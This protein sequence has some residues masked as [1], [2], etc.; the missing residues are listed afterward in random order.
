MPVLTISK[1]FDKEGEADLS[2]LL[3]SKKWIGTVGQDFGSLCLNLSLT[4]ALSEIS[5]AFSYR[6]IPTKLVDF[7]EV[8]KSAEIVTKWIVDYFDPLDSSTSKHLASVLTSEKKTVGDALRGASPVK[9]TDR[10]PLILQHQGHSRTIVG[11]E[12]MKNGNVNLLTFD[13]AR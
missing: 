2:P 3:N 12:M 8:D 6:G 13:P 1:G 11:Y 5:V 7:A 9:I 10:M 4:C